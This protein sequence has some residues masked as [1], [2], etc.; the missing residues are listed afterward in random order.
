M[1]RKISKNNNDGKI[2]NSWRTSFL[3]TWRDD[4]ISHQAGQSSTVSRCQG[5]HHQRAKQLFARLKNLAV[6]AYISKIVYHAG[7]PTRKPKLL[8]LLHFSRNPLGVNFW[9]LPHP[10]IFFGLDCFVWRNSSSFHFEKQEL[11][12]I[13]R[14]KSGVGLFSSSKKGIPKSN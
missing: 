3:E 13:L 11:D 4:Y 12:L 10:K 14:T 5:W 7:Q 1:R 6:E 8:L 9:H 2:L